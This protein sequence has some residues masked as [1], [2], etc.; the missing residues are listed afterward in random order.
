MIIPTLVIF[1]VVGMY[2]VNFQR[3]SVREESRN[4]LKRFEESVDASVYNIGNQ[5]DSLTANASFSLSLKKILDHSTMKIGESTVFSMIKNF[6]RSYLLI[7]WHSIYYFFH[8]NRYI[9][10]TS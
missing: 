2:V 7:S 1:L 6:F 5:I 9:S 4:S 10:F 8:F 3:Q